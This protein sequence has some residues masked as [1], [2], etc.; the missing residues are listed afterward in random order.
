MMLIYRGELISEP[1]ALPRFLLRKLTCKTVH[2][3]TP[4]G[5]EEW[6]RLS[7][8]ERF[9]WLEE[10]CW[11]LPPEERWDAMKRHRAKIV[12]LLKERAWH[13]AASSVPPGNA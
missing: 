11:I 6:H 4:S 2:A 5:D 13:L 10:H 12:G 8:I 9:E 7:P 1:A 3:S